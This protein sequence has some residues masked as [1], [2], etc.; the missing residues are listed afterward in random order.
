M[1][2][3]QN[4]DA[5]RRPASTG[6][7][8]THVKCAAENADVQF[9]KL[10][11]KVTAVDAAKGGETLV[12]LTADHG[13]TYGEDVQRQDDV[14]RGRH[15][16]VLRAERRLGRRVGAPT[17]C[18]DTTTYNNPSPALAAAAGRRTTSP[19]VYGS[20][21]VEAWLVEPSPRPRCR[22]PRQ[23]LEAARRRS[24]STTARATVSRSYGTNKM[25]QSEKDWWKDHGQEIVDTMAAPNG[26]DIVALLHDKTS[27]GVYG[28]HGGAQ[29]SVQRV[30][31]VFWSPSL[32]YGGS[33][34]R[35]FQTTGRDA[36]DPRD[37]GHP[38]HGAGR[39][40]GEAPRALTMRVRPTSVAP[41]HRSPHVSATASTSFG[42]SIAA[43]RPMT[44]RVL[45]TETHPRAKTPM[46]SA[47][48]SIVKG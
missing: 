5:R 8:Q 10:L 47:C 44:P 42:R 13:A 33:T 25:T 17:S 26:P 20:T 9:G 19:F 35:P 40:H 45:R 31:M 21:A 6:A 4:A 29:E 39:R 37:H 1:W 41:V 3:A 34:G 23:R 16:L 28:D 7:E 22:K 27:Y 36:D 15:E 32:A 12:V 11:D 38:A 43:G 30:P 2:G 14:G 24:P 46:A 48:S 18:L